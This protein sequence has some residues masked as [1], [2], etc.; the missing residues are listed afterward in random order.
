L[1]RRWW[2]VD[3]DLR[4]SWTGR[5]GTF[6]EAFGVGEVCGVKNGLAL[7]DDGWRLA[8]M[9]GRRGQE[10]DAGVVMF[11]VVPVEEVYGEDTGVL[12]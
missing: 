9:Q 8:M 1:L 3:P 6:D 2:L 7:S 11:L 10:T 5:W 12:D 4:R